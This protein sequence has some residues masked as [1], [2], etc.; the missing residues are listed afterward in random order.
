MTD[1]VAIIE[2]SSS[3]VVIES[4]TSPIIVMNAASPVVIESA[5]PANELFVQSIGIHGPK[6]DSSL[7]PGPPGPIGPIGPQGPQ[8]TIELGIVIDGGNF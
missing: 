1:I 4:E 6:G 7:V 3:P 5:T 8:A 2:N